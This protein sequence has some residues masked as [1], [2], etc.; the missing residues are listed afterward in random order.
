MTLSARD[1]TPEIALT[2]NS[3]AIENN[4]SYY[5][6]VSVL[7]IKFNIIIFYRPM[8]LVFVCIYIFWKLRRLCNPV[9]TS[10][11]HP[12]F[13]NRLVKSYTYLWVEVVK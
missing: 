8:T 2:L 12:P 9:S 1:E 11:P 3:I 6:H 13:A 4:L 5:L 10:A 7:I